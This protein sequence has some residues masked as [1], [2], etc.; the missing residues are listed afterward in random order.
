VA[1]DIA[2][3]VQWHSGASAASGSCTGA[4]EAAALY[5][6]KQRISP[7]FLVMHGAPAVP[8]TELDG[9]DASLAL[10]D[11]RNFLRKSVQSTSSRR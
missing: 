2:Q 11:T 3:L 8:V 10:F 7:A 5:A 4:R 6:E 1:Q 9:A